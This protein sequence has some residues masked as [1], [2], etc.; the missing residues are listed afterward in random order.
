[1]GYTVKAQGINTG[2]NTRDKYRE[3]RERNTGI[4]T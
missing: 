4:K 2:I 1:M 3:N